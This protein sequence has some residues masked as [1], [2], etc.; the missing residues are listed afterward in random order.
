MTLTRGLILKIAAAA[1]A[2]GLA[3]G[4]GAIW[5]GLGRYSA[6]FPLNLSNEAADSIW[7]LY[8]QTKAAPAALPM[9]DD[10]TLVTTFVELHAR[11]FHI[12]L[13]D[14][15][16]EG[17]AVTSVGGA[18]LLLTHDGRFFAGSAAEGIRQ[19]DAITPPEN[20]LSQYVEATQRPPHNPDAQNYA[21]FRYNDVSYFSTDAGAGLL[22][23]YTYFDGARECYTSRLSRF[24]FEDARASVD[25]LVIGA[26]DWRLLFETQPCLPMH[27]PGPSIYV[28][29]AGG[30]LV[31]ES[32]TNTVYLASGNYDA[33]N[34]YDN[35]AIS[36]DPTNDYGK[37]IAI[38]L[39]TGASRHLSLGHRNPQ[40]IA[41]DQ[42]GRIWIVE[43]GP[44]GGD[45]LNLIVEGGNY[46]WPHVA[47][48][49]G[50]NH[51]PLPG[52]TPAARHDGFDRP[53]LAWS[54]SIGPSTILAVR[55]FHQA[56]DG[57]LIVG[58]LR[59][60][61]LVLIRIVDDRVVLAEDIP[62]GQRVRH[63]HQHTDGSIVLW[64]GK[65]EL[66]IFTSGDLTD[67]SEI[68][69]TLVA[70]LDAPD[71]IREAVQIELGECMQC[72]SLARGGDATAPS[73]ARVFGA[74]IG[75]S[76]YAYYSPALANARGA[77]TRERLNQF[78]RDPSGAIPGTVM[79]NPEIA[80]DRVR[81]AMVDVLAAL[82]V[83]DD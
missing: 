41:Q 78:L 64:N 63:L 32:A 1:V 70:R 76:D 57:D 48:G 72:H 55:G 61:K 35:V 13:A 50:Y 66:M 67:E 77:W 65:N 53:T 2:L 47:Y 81:A 46:G 79:P 29:E 18:L 71:R 5:G 37:V 14:R 69:E 8:S 60:Q 7:S 27:P 19:V 26:E 75:S 21:N 39:D 45:E 62:I 16:G 68:A 42:L 17:G 36:Q 56:W 6:R 33:P 22:L 38:D 23:S 51:L 11:V 54:P 40:G 49:T 80:D 74:D 43:H 44:R 59:G 58:A 24:D 20:G 25:D 28:Q 31:V 4:V 82:A 52:D 83:S 12:P 73:L 30:R 34:L 15:G 10:V 9:G 3:L